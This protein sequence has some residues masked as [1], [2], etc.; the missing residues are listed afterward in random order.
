MIEITIKIEGE[1]IDEIKKEL[2]SLFD[3]TGIYT[4]KG[5]G[6]EFVDDLSTVSLDLLNQNFDVGAF[7]V[8][9]RNKVNTLE[10]LIEMDPVELLAFNHFGPKSLENVFQMVSKWLKHNYNP[11]VEAWTCKAIKYIK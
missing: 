6:R 7:H 8:L 11:D 4:A 9:V 2:A 1:N 10:D 5:D 3:K